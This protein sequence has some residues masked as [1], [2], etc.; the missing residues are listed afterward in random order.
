[1][2][3]VIRTAA[4]LGLSILAV[5][6][7]A[8][9][10][11][12]GKIAR[13]GVIGGSNDISGMRT[14]YQ[15]FTEGLRDLGYE[16]GRNIAFE[17]R[18]AEGH[19]E[20]FPDIAAELVALK[21]DVIVSGVCGP[22]LNAARQATSTIPIVVAACNDDMVETGIIANLAHPGGNVTGL[23]KMAPELTA[24]RLELLKE[25]APAASH[26]AVLWDP[27]YS[28]FSPEWQALRARARVEGVT[29]QSVEARNP[30]EFDKAF[31]AMI[32]ERADAALTFSD[33]QTY[34]FAN[35]IAELAAQNK[36]PLMSPFREITNGGGLMSYGPSLPDLMRRAAGYVDKILKGA[37]PA[38]LPVEQPTKIDFVINLKTAKT[39][40]LNVPEPL[41]IRADEVI[42]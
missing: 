24:K 26:V 33:T 4:L 3:G 22:M 9:A 36:L 8:Q 40:G 14:G 28:A 37:N 42:E 39:L 18:S 27:G 41:L 5:S 13:I 19:P 15:P 2:R 10:Q 29:L 11:Q 32:R 12:S 20:R 35:R 17:F 1:M 38:N 23:S 34:G 21:V 6:S 16:E 25:M 30:S 31:T 7:V